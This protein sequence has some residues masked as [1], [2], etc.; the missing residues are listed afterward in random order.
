MG[1]GID[2]FAQ[3]LSTVFK[4]MTSGLKPGAPLVFTYHHNDLA[5]YYP[6]VVAIL[7][8]GLTCSASLPCPAEMGASIH[9]NGTGSSVI[10]TIFVCRSTGNVPAKWIV[11][12]IVDVVE[13]VEEDLKK[14]RAGAVKPTAGDIR[15]IAYGHI[16]RLAIWN[17]RS[18]WDNNN[19]ITGRLDMVSKWFN[20]FGGWDEIKNNIGTSEEYYPNLPLFTKGD[21]WDECDL[22]YDEIPF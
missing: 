22:A 21:T 18:I 16:V 9:I 12:S 13:L 19:S 5:A 14:L 6:L 3:G 7:D 17:L 8:A 10:D 11:D 20:H 15:C 2:H 1:R 4:N